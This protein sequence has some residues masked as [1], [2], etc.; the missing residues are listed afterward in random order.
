MFSAASRIPH[1]FGHVPHSIH[2]ILYFDLHVK[3]SPSH[4]GK[5]LKNRSL[6]D[7]YNAGF[8]VVLNVQDTLYLFWTA[9]FMFQK[10]TKLRMSKTQHSTDIR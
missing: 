10:T 1:Y 6:F 5:R 2:C 7:L 9:F 4:R 8:Q 3:K